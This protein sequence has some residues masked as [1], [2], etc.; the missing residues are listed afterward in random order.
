MT[1]ARP[2]QPQVRPSP[3]ERVFQGDG[4]VARDGPHPLVDAPFGRPFSSEIVYDERDCELPLSLQSS[5]PPATG[6]GSC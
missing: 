6:K 2:R 4:W 3:L 1:S 5:L